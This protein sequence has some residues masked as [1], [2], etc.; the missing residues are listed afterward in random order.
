M[1]KSEKKLKRTIT[2]GSVFDVLGFSPEEA[3]ALKI[4]SDLH[5]EILRVIKKKKYTSRN[6]EKILNEPQPRISEL[7]NGRISKMSI[8]KLIMYLQK[9]GISISIKAAP[10][11]RA[12]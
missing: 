3:E 5:I 6:L 8:E 11:K 12:A 10:I 9:L 1:S 7:M 4:K 2:Y